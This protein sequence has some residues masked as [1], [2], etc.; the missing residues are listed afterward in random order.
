MTSRA[1]RYALAWVVAAALAVTVGVLAVTSAGAGVRDRGQVGTALP[2]ADLAATPSADPD[3]QRVRTELDDE[4]GA[5]VVECRGTVAHGIEA[6]PDTAA[7]WQVVSFETE[8]D[9][10]IDAVFSQ[11]PRSIEIEVFCNRGRPTV[12]DREEHVLEGD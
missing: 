10:D 6:R 8:P 5:L 7:G 4:F 9:D 3:A 2:P 12:S 1:L 11:G